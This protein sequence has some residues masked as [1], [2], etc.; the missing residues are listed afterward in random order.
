VVPALD[1]IAVVALITLVLTLEWIHLARR[2]R[3][4]ELF[5]A[6][7]PRDLFDVLPTDLE[8]VVQRNGAVLKLDEF[9]I[10]RFRFRG[11]FLVAPAT[12]PISV[13]RVVILAPPN[14]VNLGERCGVV[15]RL[16][17]LS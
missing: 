17:R 6:D 8:P 13:I 4:V 15:E 12:S 7:N 9:V 16:H 10:L 3:E 5:V 2:F 1:R 14:L 11:V